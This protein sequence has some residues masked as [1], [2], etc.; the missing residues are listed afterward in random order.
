MMQTLSEAPTHW[1]GSVTLT[2]IFM[3][4][5]WPLQHFNDSSGTTV[6]SGTHS[7]GLDAKAGA[8]APT[9]MTGTAQAAPV[10]MVRRLGRRTSIPCD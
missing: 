7:F 3:F 6:N 4:L 10:A 5:T 1:L 8:D 2:T 9:A